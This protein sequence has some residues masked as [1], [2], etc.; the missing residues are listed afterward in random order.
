MS[1]KEKTIAGISWTFIENISQNVILFVMGI[2]LARLLT[3][4]DFGLIGITMI[5]LAV[6]PIFTDGGFGVA[7]IRKTECTNIEYSSVFFM[8]MII[9]IFLYVLLFISSPW[10]ADYFKSVDLTKVLRVLGLNLIITSLGGINNII[11]TKK[12]NFK[13]IAKASFIS[14]LTSGIL[15]VTLAYL[16]FGVWALVLRTL[17]NSI[18][19]LLLLL[20]FNFWIPALVFDIKVLKSLFKFGSNLLLSNIINTLFQNIYY[21]IIGK[22]YSPAQLGYFTR[23]DMFRALTAQ[24]LTMVVSKVSFPVLSSFQDDNE[25]M[26]TAYKT[27]IRSTLFVS[28]IVMFIM[29]GSARAMILAV[30]G[31]KWEPSV[32]LLQLISLA[33]FLYPIHAMNLNILNVKG[34]SDLYLKVELLKKLNY[35]P[36]ILLGVYY[37]IE[38]MLVAG[39]FSSFISYFINASAGGGLINY[40]IKEQLKDIWPSVTFALFVGMIVFSLEFL[41]NGFN[42]WFVFLTQGFLGLFLTILGGELLRF[43]DYLYIKY[44]VIDKFPILRKFTF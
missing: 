15:A 22:I 26:K 20:I 30:L 37:G 44:I 43:N 42:P 8:N 35:I 36:I 4:E 10:I 6:L 7:L 18:L 33:G 29:A 31:E 2:V 5:F 12:L 19:N 40:S 1:L 32:I 14:N 17:L 34:R 13:A 24:N 28:S 3:P 38:S 11:L 41:L 25:R 23:A 9:S 39:I 21:F 16:G 27:L